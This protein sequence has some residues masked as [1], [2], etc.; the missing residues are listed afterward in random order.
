MVSPVYSKA[1]QQWQ[2]TIADG[3]VARLALDMAVKKSV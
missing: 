2:L 1:E 3:L